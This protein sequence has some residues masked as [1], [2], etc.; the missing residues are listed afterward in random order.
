MMPRDGKAVRV[1]RP[2]P[3]PHGAGPTNTRAARREEKEDGDAVPT[4]QQLVRKGRQDKVAKTSTPALK[5]S[6]QRRGVCTRVYTTTP[7]KP[8]SALRKVAR[9]RLTSQI[10]VTAYIPGVG[11]NLQEHSIVLVRGGRVRDLP[12]VRYKVIRGSLDTQGV[13][14]RKQARSRYGAKKEKS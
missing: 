11:H 1:A 9:V 2:Q 12:G 10:E 3:A 5:G 8:N 7:K 4:I 14:N 6:P 13:R